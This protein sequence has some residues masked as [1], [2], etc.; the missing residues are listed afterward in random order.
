MKKLFHVQWYEDD[1]QLICTHEKAENTDNIYSKCKDFMRTGNSGCVV[2]GFVKSVFVNN[3]L[4]VLI[5]NEYYGQ[6]IKHVQVEI[7]LLSI[8][9]FDL[10]YTNI[11]I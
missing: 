9:L 5:I 4:Q 1:D 3:I 2:S 7:V 10:T 11:K 6:H 8:Y